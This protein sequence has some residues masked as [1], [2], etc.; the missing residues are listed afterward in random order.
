MTPGQNQ[1]P[2]GQPITPITLLPGH[3]WSQFVD[4][5]G[6]VLWTQTPTPAPPQTNT[7]SQSNHTNQTRN[8]LF[9][10]PL[11]YI[12][13]DRKS[14]NVLTKSNTCN[15]GDLDDVKLWYDDLKSIFITCTQGREI[16][17][18]LSQLH[19]NYDFEGTILPPAHQSNYNPAK[20]EFRAISNVLRVLLTKTKTFETNCENITNL[21]T[22]HK[23]SSC[24]FELLMQIFSDVF[25][26]LGGTVIDVVEEINNLTYN[27]SDTLDSFLAKTNAL[28][29]K[30]ENTKQIFPPNS[31]IHKFIKELR[32]EPT[33][34]VKT[35]PIFLAYNDH[36]Q[37]MCCNHAW[38]LLG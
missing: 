32:R 11:G 8:S 13:F 12:T 20:N 26:H 28:T 9:T 22:I 16:L 5:A 33:V 3:V 14:W 36:I 6:R 25:P 24:G 15:S 4:G 17:P 31:I 2:G 38:T 18:E 21:V 1:V 10:A 37:R 23:S 27:K 29:R 34:E 19:K 7:T 30:I 35:S